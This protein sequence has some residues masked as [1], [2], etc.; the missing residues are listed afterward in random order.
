MSNPPQEV[1][2]NERNTVIDYINSIIANNR[3]VI[4]GIDGINGTGKTNLAYYLAAD[5]KFGL[6]SLD[7]F[8]VHKLDCYLKALNSGLLMQKLLQLKN[9]SFIIEGCC[10]LDVARIFDIQP[11]IFIYCKEISKL[12][13]NAELWHYGNNFDEYANNNYKQSITGFEKEIYDYHARMRPWEQA[14]IIYKLINQEKK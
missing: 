9:K 14:H 5:L 7:C 3:L 12:G 1:Y 10:L 11:N 6:I 2:F 8:L 4:I 13:H